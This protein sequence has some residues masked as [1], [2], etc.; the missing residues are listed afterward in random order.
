[1]KYALCCLRPLFN[2][3]EREEDSSLQRERKQRAV[4]TAVV[5]LVLVNVVAL[6]HKGSVYTTAGAVLI[7]APHAVQLGYVLMKKAAPELLLE[8]VAYC[9]VVAFVCFDIA[10]R[11]AG[12]SVVWPFAVLALDAILLN[13]LPTRVGRNCLII[14]IASLSG[15]NFMEVTGHW[16]PDTMSREIPSIC[17]CDDPP[18][19]KAVLTGIA[20]T[21]VDCAVVVIDFILTR[22]FAVRLLHEKAAVSNAVETAEQVS[23]FLSSFDLISAETVL[24]AEV[25]KL[26]AGLT[27]ALGQILQNLKTYKPYLPRSALPIDLIPTSDPEAAPSHGSL[28]TATPPA[29]GRRGTQVLSDSDGEAVVSMETM[30]AG[31]V[32]VPLPA[33]PIRAVAF[34]KASLAVINVHNTLSLLE[35]NL[36]GFELFFANL[37]ATAIEAV[38]ASRGMA[39]LFLGDKILF[40]FNTARQC[41]QHAS[42][43]VRAMK[44]VKRA[45]NEV[46]SFNA[47]VATGRAMCGDMGCAQMRRFSVLGRLSLVVSGFERAGRALGVGVV[48]NRLCHRDCE[49]DHETR[50]IPRCVRILKRSN[51]SHNSADGIPKSISAEVPDTEA[52][53]FLYEV[54]RS[55]ATKPIPQEWMYEVGGAAE[56]WSAY[57]T[58]VAVYL[59]GSTIDDAQALVAEAEGGGGENE[60]K[61]PQTEAFIS[62]M[63]VMASEQPFEVYY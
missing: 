29:R 42:A 46:T 5:F 56:R 37:L 63:A 20:H 13:Q 44:R 10:S 61:G 19:Q 7:A 4:S 30:P 16:I 53:L 6:L 25:R 36:T 48:C 39:D 40:S 45:L 43:A 57:N 54:L 55:E 33:R 1:M 60:E 34:L 15:V 62:A 9:M 17:D 32:A 41:L 52:G 35:T 24:D 31:G 51:G 23:T 2:Y 18:C 12:S 26:P 49:F 11:R 28:S 47:G 59:N 38:E 58:A 8:T 27:H 14:M 22:G 3:V 21:L 50:L